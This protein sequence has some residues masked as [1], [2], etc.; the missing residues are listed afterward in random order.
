[1]G[2]VFQH[3][4]IPLVIMAAC[5]VTLVSVSTLQLD[6]FET[7]LRMTNETLCIFSIYVFLKLEFLLSNYI[8]R[9]IY[10]SYLKSWHDSL[11]RDF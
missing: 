3:K 6:L 11:N 1:M 10:L 5:F 9:F 8:T 7:L 4:K 2:C